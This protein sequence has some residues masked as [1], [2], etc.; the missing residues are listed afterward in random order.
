MLLASPRFTLIS[1][2]TAAVLVLGSGWRLARRSVEKHIPPDRAGLR[3][4][5][6]QLQRELLQL[7]ALFQADLR[8]LANATARADEAQ[9]RH[10]C[11]NLYGV[12]Q[13]SRL[14]E[15]SDRDWHL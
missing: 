13:Y 4:F 5:A 10:L 15:I 12:V 9:I 6:T 7:E 1:L 14:S 8:E 2:L 11:D 3:E